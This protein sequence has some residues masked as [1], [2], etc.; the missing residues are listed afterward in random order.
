VQ[1]HARNL[2]GCF[3]LP[4]PHEKYQRSTLHKVVTVSDQ[5]PTIED[6][7]S[8]SPDTLQPGPPIWT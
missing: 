3:V 7:A 6:V 2:R 5:E 4:M 1:L 8:S